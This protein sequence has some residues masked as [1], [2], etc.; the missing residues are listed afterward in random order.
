V[1]KSN[2]T[3]LKVAFF[4][5][6]R[7]EYGLLR[8]S[9]KELQNNEKFHVELFVGG[10]HLAKRYG[11]TVEEIEKDCAR[12]D[13]TVEFLIDSDTP[14]AFSKSVGIAIVS[15]A[16]VFTNDKPDIIVILG[17]R[18]ELYTAVVPAL[19]HNIPIVHIEGGAKTIGAIDEQVR[20]SITKLSHVHVVSTKEYAENISR[21]GEED[22]RIQVLGSPGIE[23]I[24]RFRL[25]SIEELRKELG[26]DLSVPTIL[27]TYHPVTLERKITTEEQI[28]NLL[29]A[30][31]HFKDF[32]IIFTASGA[33]VESNV[34]MK[35]IQKFVE[36][37]QKAF[38]FDNLGSLLYL[39][40]AKHCKAVVGNSSSG[41]IEIPS[42]KVPTVNIGDRQKGRVAAES[43]I[44]CGYDSKDIVKAIEKAV[45]DEEFLKK[46]S[47]V[48]NPYDPYE[49]GDF[50]GRFLKVLE[51]IVVDEKLLRKELNFEV[52]KEQ[53][54]ALL[55]GKL[56]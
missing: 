34:I 15:V 42:L 56:V 22:W 17:D 25:K 36:S 7:A 39:S 14:A 41:I 3:K 51:S 27:V 9:I 24:Y 49:D 6:T 5:F 53:W 55:R 16:Q 8:W 18:Y 23:N 33:E 43:V 26:I 52:R 30:L 48:R 44:H 32:Q 40:V 54:N 4:T 50:S 10:A 31:I 21:M 38:L 20:H 35:K 45:G 37:N 46:V 11:I 1:V 2:M 12:I 13:H 29:E 19:L 28:V 47:K